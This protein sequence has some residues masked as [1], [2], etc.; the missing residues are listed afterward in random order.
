MPGAKVTDPA[1]LAALDGP[2]APGPVTDPA[3]LAQL[4][5][6]PTTRAG[7]ME[8]NADAYQPFSPVQ[9]SEPRPGSMVEF[10]QNLDAGMPTARG[11]APG[12][13]SLFSPSSPERAAEQQGF[14]DLKAAP[15][16]VA[17][18]DALDQ[19]PQGAMVSSLMYAPMG[20]PTA[21]NPGPLA[22]R[23]KEK[24]IESG[25]K[26]LTGNRGSISV[27]KPLSEGA[28]EES[29]T[30]GAIKPFSNVQAIDKRLKGAR[31]ELGQQYADIIDQ[32]EAKGITGPDATALAVKLL[33]EAKATSANSLG[34]PTPGLLESTAEEL[35][36][37]PTNPQGRL[38]LT[39][40]ESMKRTLQDEAATE[41]DKLLG[42]MRPLGKAKILV[43]SRMREAIEDEV[44]AQAAKAPQEAAAFEPVKQRLGNTIEASKAAEEAAA[45][46]GRN[47]GLSLSDTVAAGA[48]GAAGG[49]GGAAL[50][51]AINK[52]A[53]TRGPATSARFNYWLY[54][55]LSEPRAPETFMGL[56]GAAASADPVV[57]EMIRAMQGARVRV[58]VGAADEGEDRK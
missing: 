29:I 41:Y 6:E 50:M 55:K 3:L 42:K 17:F 26:A 27:K 52:A 19:S 8:S 10:A 28:V 12:V 13:V 34:S 51:A 14:A 39:Q 35:V 49:W 9:P 1:L 38:G 53:R 31:A 36:T 44:K 33:N 43:A 25:R 11:L 58:P 30:S 21:P 16:M 56:P 20:T 32:L 57:Q 54:K 37:K 15:N 7:G 48:G 18:A 4:N 23:F 2:S 24:A 5:G 47:Q 40:A 46:A 22:L 45:R